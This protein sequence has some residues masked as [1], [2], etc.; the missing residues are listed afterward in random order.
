[1][2]FNTPYCILHILYQRL[3]TTP[4]CED[5]ST[6]SLEGRR[7]EEKASHESPSSAS[8]VLIKRMLILTSFTKV[9]VA[10]HLVMTHI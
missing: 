1:M 7:G 4:V 5:Y 2:G 8:R 9:R 6:H 10:V 3:P